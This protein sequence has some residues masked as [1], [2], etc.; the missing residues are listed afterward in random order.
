MSERSKEDET[1]HHQGRNNNGC[2]GSNKV[3]V[4]QIT[5]WIMQIRV[6]V[7]KLKARGLISFVFI[8]ISIEND[9]FA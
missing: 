6:H 5:E 2:V 8:V 3:S 4:T 9:G 1:D 7:F